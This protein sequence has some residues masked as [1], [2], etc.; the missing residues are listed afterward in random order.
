VCS[1]DLKV[2]QDI[3]QSV[4]LLCFDEFSVTDIADAMILGRLFVELFKNNVVIV[5]TSNVAPDSLYKDGL[6]RSLFLPF[7]EVLKANVTVFELD[8]RT[9]FRLEKLNSA[10]VYLTPLDDNSRDGM[11]AAWFRLTGSIKGE[12]TE[13]ELK[14]RILS[15]PQAM[16]GVARFSFEQLC[17][18]A[19]GAADFLAISRKFH[20]VMID[21]VKI[22]HQSAPNVAKR[23]ILLIDTLYDN[24]IKLVLSAEASP[25]DLYLARSGTEAF[26][27]NRTSSR[28]VEMQ[29]EDYLG[30]ALDRTG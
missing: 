23:F 13:I 24:R 18:E 4:H 21:D 10:P 26:E 7:L 17:L 20:T 19:K 22:M 12:P 28:L 9:D 5:T 6:N 8:A 16:Q 29:S 1:S 25:H 15:V 2:A 3:A 11:D 14:G 30:G 27:F